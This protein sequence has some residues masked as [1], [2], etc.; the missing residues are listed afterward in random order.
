MSNIVYIATSLDGFIA[1]KDDSIDWLVNLPNPTKSDY[2]FSEFQD[3]LDAILIGRKTYEV[4][5]SFNPWPYSKPVF[6]LSRT[7]DA[8]SPSVAG[9]AELLNLS[10][11]DAV[12]HL[13]ARGLHE[14][15]VDGGK[16]IQEFLQEDLIDEMTITRVPV[17]L[18]SGIPLFGESGVEVRFRHVETKVFDDLLV[19]SRYVR[20]S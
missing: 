11:R 20:A 1:R 15:Y 10:P 12:T 6:V 16:T 2:G 9:K 4:V 3:R 18:G 13:H 7:L 17:I 8:L 5:L 14:I 19:R